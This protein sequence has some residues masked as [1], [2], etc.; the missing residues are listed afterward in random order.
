MYDSALRRFKSSF[1]DDTECDVW[2]AEVVARVDAGP[3]TMLDIGVGDGLSISRRCELL[4]EKSIQVRL[5]GIDPVLP[6]TVT[7]PH[8][9]V[10]VRTDFADYRP[11]ERFDLV[12]A[13][14]SLYYLGNVSAALRRMVELTRPGG[15]LVV[16]VWSS[17]CV[18]SRL[19][20]ECFAADPARVLTAE[21]TARELGELGG[22]GD[23]TL[24]RGH[25]G[26]NLDLWAS[27]DA[28]LDA[29]VQVISRS[30]VSGLVA[31]RQRARL[32]SALSRYAPVERRV[33]GIVVA[34]KQ[35]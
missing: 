10:L 16:T 24:V 30:P 7:A 20:T 19:F 27:D 28:H 29:A 11:S 18:L 6:D 12:N 34:R 17:Q 4:A 35:I 1:R 14:H 26:V 15:F 33:N 22:V 8:G 9:S 3:V 2:L 13:T 21:R 5:T 23:V 32:K 25:G 31:P